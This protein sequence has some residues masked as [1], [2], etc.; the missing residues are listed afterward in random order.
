[1][2]LQVSPYTYNAVTCNT[3]GSYVCGTGKYFPPASDFTPKPTYPYG[4]RGFGA[5]VAV[6]DFNGD[7]FDDIA[8]G[9]PGLS[10]N[11]ATLGAYGY[12]EGA[13]YLYWGTGNGVSP[14]GQKIMMPKS[15]VVSSNYVY[16]G[17]AVAFGSMSDSISAPFT[18]SLAGGTTQYRK[19]DLIVG[20]PE[21]QI[22]NP[23]GG[24]V[25][26]KGTSNVALALDSDNRL[27]PANLGSEYLLIQP[28]QCSSTNGSYVSNYNCGTAVVSTDLNQDGYDDMIFAAPWAYAASPGVL[29]LFGRGVRLL[30]LKRRPGQ[31][32][33][34]AGDQRDH[35]LRP[36]TLPPA[37]TRR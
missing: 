2:R 22:P 10:D 11:D 1:M 8:I 5:A 26:I 31:S 35:L 27:A 24:A 13:V 34:V 30:R 6:G 20:A 12:Y 37:A 19:K 15:Q 33:P 9:A 23:S 21:M 32:D 7:G 3:P 25:W 36:P 17:T 18:D 29:A 28:P 16:F 4:S 14:A